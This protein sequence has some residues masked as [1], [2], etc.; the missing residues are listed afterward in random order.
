M[1]RVDACRVRRSARV[2]TDGQSPRTCKG[3]WFASN[4]RYHL[5]ATRSAEFLLSHLY[6]DGKLH[7]S[8]R[9]GRTTDEVFL[10]DYASLI[11]GLLELYQTDFNNKWLTSTLGLAEEMVAKFDHPEGGILRY[12]LGWRASAAASQGSPGQCHSLWQRPRCRSL[13]QTLRV[14]RTRGFPRSRQIFLRLVADLSVRYP[15]AFGQWLSTAWF[16]RSRVKQVALITGS[17]ADSTVE[18]LNLLRSNYRPDL[19]LPHPPI[20]RPPTPRNYC[21]IAPC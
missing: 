1:E 8:W 3:T 17:D 5:L 21:R 7:R 6:H 16:A 18:M 4:H 20:P 9:D 13:A 19:I 11:L 15:T 14:H 12:S 10:E 2:L